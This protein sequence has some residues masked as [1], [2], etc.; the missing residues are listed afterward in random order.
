MKDDTKLVEVKE[1]LER[2]ENYLVAK[3]VP[4]SSALRKDIRD[5]IKKL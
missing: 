4:P 3:G 5:T 2:V 1:L